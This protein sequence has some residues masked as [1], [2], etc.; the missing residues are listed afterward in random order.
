[1]I[2]VSVTDYPKK[3]VV[4]TCLNCGAEVKRQQWDTYWDYR[5][6]LFSMPKTR[7]PHCDLGPQSNSLKW[8][9][10]YDIYGRVTADWEAKTDEGD[11]LIWKHGR[12]WKARYRAFGSGDPQM[13][14]VSSTRDGAKRLCERSRFNLANKK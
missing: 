1:M 5:R 8:E 9:K 12:V 3:E 13:L 6:L 7:C 11:F 4:A 14:G 10:H 2:K